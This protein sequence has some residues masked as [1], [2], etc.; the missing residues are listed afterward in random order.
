MIG[1][2]GTKTVS[3]F[4]DQEKKPDRDIFIAQAFRGNDLRR[5]DSFG[6]ARAAPI[7]SR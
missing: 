3:F 6:I 7:N 5:D 1:D 4:P 2:F